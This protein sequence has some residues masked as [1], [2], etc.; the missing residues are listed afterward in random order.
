MHFFHLKR[1]CHFFSPKKKKKKWGC[2]LF[3]T[4]G[5]ATSK[6]TL[7]ALTFRHV[8]RGIR[9]SFHESAF[10]WFWP[11]QLGGTLCTLHVSLVVLDNS[12]IGAHKPRTCVSLLRHYL[13]H[14]VCFGRRNMDKIMSVLFYPFAVSNYLNAISFMRIWGIE[15]RSA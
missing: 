7:V 5:K 3:L 8:T 9:T 10:V 13:L 11:G 12:L 1:G 15:I 6:G 2:L 4:K 14:R